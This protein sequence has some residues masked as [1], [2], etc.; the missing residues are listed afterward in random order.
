[1]SLFT[2]D[3]TDNLSTTTSRS[4]LC[5]HEYGDTSV[6]SNTSE[7]NAHLKNIP[8]AYEREQKRVV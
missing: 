3:H 6:S 5:D 7:H 1:M 4:T 2:Y 8:L